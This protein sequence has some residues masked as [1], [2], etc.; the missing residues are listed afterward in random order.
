[1]QSQKISISLP[2]SLLTFIE[3]Y[4]VAKGCQS[5]SQVILEALE[6]LQ[7]RELE[8]AYREASFEVEDAWEV[9]VGDG[10]KDETW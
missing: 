6:L 8:Q 4:K 1:M 2:P 7:E 3:D 5:R 9:T 10:L